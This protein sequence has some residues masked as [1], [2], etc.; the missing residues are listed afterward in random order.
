MF[1]FKKYP[2][3]PRPWRT[4]LRGSCVGLNPQWNVKTRSSSSDLVYGSLVH[5]TNWFLDSGEIY[6]PLSYWT[7]IPVRTWNDIESI[8]QCT[9]KPTLMYSPLVALVCMMDSLI[10]VVNWLVSSSVLCGHSD[11]LELLHN[12]REYCKNESNRG[13]SSLLKK[14][15][16]FSLLICDRMCHH[17]T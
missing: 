6:P 9:I 8:M 14:V 4:V 16:Q 3:V 1:L 2:L 5:N 13:N 15:F 7:T 10:R 17:L 12:F 11:S